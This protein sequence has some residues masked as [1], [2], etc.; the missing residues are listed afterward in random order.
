MVYITAGTKQEAVDI[1]KVLVAEKLAACTNIL[2]GMESFYW[3]DEKVQSSTEVILIAK[4]SPEKFEQLKTKVLEL[5]SYDCPCV[6]AWPIEK[7]NEEYLA[8]LANATQ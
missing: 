4:T 6:V 3:W 8:W 5:H 2:P 7:G 1:S